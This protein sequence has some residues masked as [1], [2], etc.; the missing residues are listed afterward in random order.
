MVMAHGTISGNERVEVGIMKGE[1]HREVRGS[2]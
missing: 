2:P 1:E